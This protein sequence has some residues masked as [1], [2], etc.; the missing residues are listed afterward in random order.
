MTVVGYTLD[1]KILADNNNTIIYAVIIILYI[2][3]YIYIQYCSVIKIV[4]I[5]C[6]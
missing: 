6:M 2:C 4:V 3:T 1:T 5:I